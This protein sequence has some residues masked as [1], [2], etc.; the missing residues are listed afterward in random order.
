[1]S[2]LS[3]I[4]DILNLFIK[5]FM[6]LMTNSVL[7]FNM[8]SFVKLLPFSSLYVSFSIAFKKQLK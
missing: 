4:L 6:I 2:L 5:S 7:I 8:I 1:M 3:F